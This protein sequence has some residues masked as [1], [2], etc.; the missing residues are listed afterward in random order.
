MTRHLSEAERRAQILRAA[1]TLFVSRG[2]LSTR[3]EDVARRA[4]LSKGAVYHYFPSKRAIFDALVEAE[5]AQTVR[6]LDEAAR[7]P[8]PAHER[9]VVLGRQ[10]L[11]YFAGLKSPPRF[12]LLMSEMA[13]R[14]DE[15]REK[16]AAIHRRFV[17]QLAAIIE[18]GQRDGVFRRIDPHAVAAMLKAFVDG[19]S[20][21]SAVGIRPDVELLA[22]EGIRLVMEGLLAPPREEASDDG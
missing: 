14:D 3:V 4:Q 12:F 2:Y 10:Y 5:Q 16:V 21:Q 13:I 6:F 8:R 7:D 9:L 19:L 11:D 18:E 17:D 1:R 15:L 22:A 20:G